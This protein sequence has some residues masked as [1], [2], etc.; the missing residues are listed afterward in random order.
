MTHRL[1]TIASV[2]YQCQ[3]YDVWLDLKPYQHEV[4]VN[5]LPTQQLRHRGELGRAHRAH[6]CFP[7]VSN[8]MTVGRQQGEAQPEM[9]GFGVGSC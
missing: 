9:G 8:D 7:S 2:S 5:P 4:E 6:A 1:R 3:T